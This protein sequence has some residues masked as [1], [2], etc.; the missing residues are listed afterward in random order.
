M[1]RLVVLFALYVILPSILLPTGDYSYDLVNDR[2]IYL[3]SLEFM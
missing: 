1:S 3:L 2:I